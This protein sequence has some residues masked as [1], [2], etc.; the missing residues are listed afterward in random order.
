M[1]PSLCVVLHD[2]APTTLAA[3]ERLMQSIAEVAT[4]PLT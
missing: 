1:T 3:C 4:V 2:V